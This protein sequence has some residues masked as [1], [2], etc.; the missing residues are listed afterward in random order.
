MNINEIPELRAEVLLNYIY[1]ELEDE[2]IANHDGSFYRNYNRD[3]LSLDV[4]ENR[5]RLARDGFLKLLPQGLLNNEAELKDNSKL[6][7][8]ERHK[9]LEWRQKLL[10][11]AFLPIDTLYFRRQ[12]RI[13]RSI[14]ELLNTK[15]EYV[16]EKYF[17]FD[18]NAEKNPYVREFAVLLPYVRGR[19]GDFGLLRSLLS[20]I[21]ECKVAMVEHRYSHTDSTKRWTPSLRY[22]LLIPGLDT[23]AYRTMYQDIRPLVDFLS[24]WFVPVEMVFDIVIKQHQVRPFA[25][26]RL[27]LDYNTELDY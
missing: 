17:N 3:A 24:E 2:W 16:L 11:E 6:D 8:R 27:V 19:R 21:F 5:V 23:S 10:T 26:Q 22:E 1:P 4:N 18:L 20:A 15:L 14:S 25:S 13:E 12:L 7:V 9:Q